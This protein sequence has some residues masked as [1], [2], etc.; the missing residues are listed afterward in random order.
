MRVAW[1]AAIGACGLWLAACGPGNAP[2]EATDSVLP[3]S[4]PTTVIPVAPVPDGIAVVINEV[5][6][7]NGSTL[8]GAYGV[9]RPDWVELYNTG[10]LS[11]DLGLL[12][13]QKGD[14]ELF[15]LPAGT[16]LPPGE[17]VIVYAGT[18]PEGLPK[19]AVAEGDNLWT[20][21]RLNKDEDELRLIYDGAHILDETAFSDVHEDIAWA[22]IP[23]GSDWV[24]TAWPT[25]RALNGGEASPT[26][27]VPDERMFVTDSVH[28]ITFTMDETAQENI[29]NADRPEVPVALEIDGISYASVGL[30]LKGSA[31]YNT[32][33]GKP[34]FVVDLNEFISGEKFRT[35]KK[36]KLHN[37]LVL[38]PTRTR[39]FITYQLANAAGIMAPRVGWAEVWVNDLYY[40]IYMVIE[41]YDDIMIEYSFPG[42]G[43]TGMIFEP[44]EAQGGGFGWGD[45]NQGGIQFDYETGPI[46]PVPAGIAALNAADDIFSGPSNDEAVANLWNYVDQENML[47]YMAW[48]TVVAHTDGYM[49]PNNWRLYVD[50][51]T[52]KVHFLPAGAEWTWDNYNGIYGSN[53][54]AAEWC[55]ANATCRFAYAEKLL[56]VANLADELDLQTQ[57][58]D[59]S[60]FLD[61]IIQLDT[62]FE[63]NAWFGGSVNAARV[64]TSA[65]LIG[66]PAA[67]RNEVYADFPELIP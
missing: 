16:E 47:T 8:M 59:Q 60:I 13:L 43:E 63:D 45:F 2:V 7:S 20:G 9:T 66:F 30:K 33:D 5:V 25:P 4:D 50:G 67:V 10:E 62:R 44:N 46:P 34:A 27:N 40:G 49:A 51:T 61:P 37:G 53:G 54:N 24:Q 36:F 64:D 22:R 15:T 55:V 52:N 56:V 18:P 28:Q 38:D 14:G 35:L 31:S 21:F 41:A 3:V 57:F 17:F 58:V 23:D 42:G 1:V 32:M 48:E 6:P 11:V 19:D 65:N 29:N 12:T 26:L 39:D